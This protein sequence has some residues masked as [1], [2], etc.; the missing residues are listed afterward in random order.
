MN[1]E[2]KTVS[3]EEFRQTLREVGTEI[4]KLFEQAFAMAKDSAGD[5]KSWAAKNVSR[6]SGTPEGDALDMIERLG[7]LRDKGFITDDEFEQK[8]ADLLKKVA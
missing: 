7:I 3:N 8:K 1:D 6:D 5:A 2:H 4:A